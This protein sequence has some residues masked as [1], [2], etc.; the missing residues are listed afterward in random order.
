[1][2]IHNKARGAIS[3]INMIPM[4]DVMLVILIIFMIITPFFVQSHIKVNLPKTSSSPETISSNDNK[5][6]KITITKDGDIY[7]NSKK[8][9]NL[10]RELS[11][12]LSKSYEKTVLVEAEKTTPVQDVITALD[13]AKKLGA[14]K[15]GISV[16]SER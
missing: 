7:V 6:I 8:T 13:T 12:N 14:G 2:K 15:V 5:I 9:K 16:I 10:E 4:I 3:E 11:L 1:M